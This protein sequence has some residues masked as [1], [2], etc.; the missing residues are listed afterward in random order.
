MREIDLTY[1]KALCKMISAKCDYAFYSQ[2][3]TH[4]QGDVQLM[5]D[6]GLEAYRFSISWSRLLPSKTTLLGT[7]T[8]FQFHGKFV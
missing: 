6:T 8:T 7:S 2:G 4:F 1:K 3:R 5:S